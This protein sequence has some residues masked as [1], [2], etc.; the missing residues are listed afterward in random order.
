MA[1]ERDVPLAVGEQ[2]L[3]YLRQTPK[4]VAVLVV[5]YLSGHLWVFIITAF[6][7]SRTRGDQLLKSVTGRTAVGL[8]WFASLLVPIYL[9]RFGGL[10]FEY[11]NILEL[12]V[13]TLV[14]GL[15]FQ[16]LVFII[17]VRF[18]DR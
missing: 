4:A 2:V 17:C 8:L 5:S 14:A 11:A 7:R 3:D 1:A 16:L 9:L 15:F 10:H 13:P 6:F 12:T 18:G